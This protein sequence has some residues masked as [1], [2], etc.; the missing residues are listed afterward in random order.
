MTD[1]P[2]LPAVAEPARAEIKFQLV[3]GEL[4]VTTPHEHVAFN[5][6]DTETLVEFLA[7]NRNGTCTITMREDTLHV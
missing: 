5:E 4:I 1:S 2:T 6:A 7:L 3:D